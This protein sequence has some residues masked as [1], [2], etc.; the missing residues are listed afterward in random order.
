MGWKDLV[1]P[2]FRPDIQI[3]RGCAIA[4]VFL[5]HL[6]PAWVPAGFLGVD[7]FFALSGFLMSAIYDPS[8]HQ[9][10][11]S[12][13][14]NRARRI[15]P[16]YFTVLL[17][18]VL[19]A[20]LLVLP[21]ELDDVARHAFYSA[22]L[23]PN[24]GY[25]MDGSYFDK[26]AFRPALH[27]WSLGVEFQFYFIV[28]IIA[29]LHKRRSSLLGAIAVASFIACLV[30]VESRPRYAFYLLPF[31]LWEFLIG[32]YAFKFAQRWLPND[33]K[34]TWKWLAVALCIGIAMI[35]FVP[36]QEIDH[37]K[38]PATF[39]T[40]ATAII[41]AVG[42]PA[43]MVSN[44]AGRFLVMLG[45]YSFSVYLVHF[46]VMIFWFYRPFESG[47]TFDA[48]PIDAAFIVGITAS[49]SIGLFHLVEDPLRKIT[50]ARATL[51][52]H[53]GL[54]CAVLAVVV[55]AKPIQKAILPKEIFQIAAAWSDRGPERCGKFTMLLNALS[56]SCPLITDTDPKARKYLLVGDSHADAIKDAMAEV[57]AR[58]RADLQLFREN[59]VLG[60][61]GCAV[62]SLGNF[63]HENQISTIILH[64]LPGHT[65]IDELRKL[66]D[67]GI[68]K[69]FKVVVIDPVPIW[70]RS[71]LRGL[72]EERRGNG[73]P[74]WLRQTID[75]YSFAN[76]KYLRE[77][78]AIEHP[79]L[80]RYSPAQL[81][82]S[83]HCRIVSA[84]G[85]PYYFDSGHLTYTGAR[86]LT[87]IFQAIFHNEQGLLR[88]RSSSSGAKSIMEVK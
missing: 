71:V 23:I 52:A 79:D 16:A 45:K 47:S 58:L 33:Q 5:Y 76:A 70:R 51:V 63:A 6:L 80:V 53:T 12:F 67:V 26:A 18:V 7:I 13:F 38:Y 11:R 35:M 88:D 37:P 78:E 31:R 65:R 15:L 48:T 74:D 64:N 24:I 50:G 34:Q 82:C 69:N 49:I 42:L 81:L 36:V 84:A 40:L 2:A 9:G 8:S 46:P 17:L 19:V 87:P 1:T 25:W 55:L 75:D 43:A 3:L 41:L 77:I 59:C 85:E 68:S 14:L 66:L 72:Y 32:F 39:V 30:M 28:P 44:W 27:F 57:A 73:K 86:Q 56:K 20:V 60:S 54:V 62:E 61:G 83:P 21:H 4:F 29:W 10:I 22:L